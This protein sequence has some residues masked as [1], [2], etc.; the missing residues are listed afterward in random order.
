MQIEYADTI[1]ADTG[2]VDWVYAHWLRVLESIK[3][4]KKKWAVR[5]RG[6]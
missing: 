5:L 1:Y 4:S 6:S 2:L 3:R